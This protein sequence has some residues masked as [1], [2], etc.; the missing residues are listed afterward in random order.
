MSAQ[1]SSESRFGSPILVTGAS[2]FLGRE[3]AAELYRSGAN[4]LATTRA[5]RGACS[6]RLT[7]H[8][9][10]LHHLDPLSR[11]DVH[12]VI[13]DVRPGLVYH[14]SGQARPRL[15]LADPASTFEANV[16]AVWVLL[17]AIRA[18]SPQTRFIVAGTLEDAGPRDALDHP[19]FVSKRCAA[20][21]CSAYARTFGLSIGLVR[22]GHVYGPDT[23]TGRLLTS[24]I[25]ARLAG[26]SCVVRDPDRM[27]DLL[28]LSDAVAGFLAA[29]KALTGP[30]LREFE[31]SSGGALAGSVVGELVDRLVTG[32]N[33][34]LELPASRT[35]SSGPPGWRARVGL[36]QGVRLTI[37]WH[38]AQA[39]AEHA[40]V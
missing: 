14:L 9:L 39:P 15:A 36:E 1:A 20:A 6:S 30:G 38:R 11:P 31:L 19:Y 10:P 22:C 18:R 37:E 40:G 23:D 2:G 5:K 29:A 21:I 28:F 35:A 12:S 17:D 3:L 4:V 8:T 26:R 34:R 33:G 7:G 27:F 25:T 32:Q 13:D 24:L 16:E